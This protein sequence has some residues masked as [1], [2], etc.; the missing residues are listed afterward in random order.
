M[1]ETQENFDDI[2]K[3]KKKSE[4]PARNRNALQT[5]TRVISI[6][7]CAKRIPTPSTP[8]IDEVKL[9]QQSKRHFLKLLYF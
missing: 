6:L 9:F 5:I 7:P 1:T 3:S 8:N 4:A 2:E